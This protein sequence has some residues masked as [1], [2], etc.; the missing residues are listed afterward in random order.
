M[1]IAIEAKVAE[2]EA[3]IVHLESQLKNLLMMMA[4]KDH[5]L[6]LKRG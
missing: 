4:P 1:S 5:T 6:K 2:L 3:R